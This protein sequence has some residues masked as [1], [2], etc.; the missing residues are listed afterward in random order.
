LATVTEGLA[1]TE[2]LLYTYQKP[3]LER[4]R[5]RALAI[6]ADNEKRYTNLIQKL[7]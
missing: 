6:I 5:D 2:G 3:I 4:H 7:K 1:D